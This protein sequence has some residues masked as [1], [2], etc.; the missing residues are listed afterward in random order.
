MQFTGFFFSLSAFAT[1]THETHTKVPVYGFRVLMVFHFS[2]S[3]A[4]YGWV[5]WNDTEDYF[6]DFLHTHT[7]TH[8][9]CSHFTGC[10]VRSV[11]NCF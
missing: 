4:A 9:A 8:R 11:T 5:S 7:D 6:N 10:R 1:Q 3:L 2:H